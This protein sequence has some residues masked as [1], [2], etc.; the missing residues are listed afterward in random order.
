MIT[1]E[2]RIAVTKLNLETLQKLCAP[3]KD[4]NSKTYSKYD[5]GRTV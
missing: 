4:A 1:H 2:D 5:T 3:G